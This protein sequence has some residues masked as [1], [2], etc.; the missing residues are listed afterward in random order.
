MLS[1]LIHILMRQDDLQTYQ[2]SKDNLLFKI[3]YFLIILINLDKQ[4]LVHQ[5]YRW[6]IQELLLKAIHMNN[7]YPI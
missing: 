1:M 5:L 2:L 7:F 6:F 4:L 3:N